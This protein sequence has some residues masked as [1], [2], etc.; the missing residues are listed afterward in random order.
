MSL[1]VKMPALLS[2]E[3]WPRKSRVSPLP[4]PMRTF[5]VQGADAGSVTVKDVP[6]LMGAL[7]MTLPVPMV[8]LGTVISATFT[9]FL[10]WLL[11]TN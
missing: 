3:F 6:G 8:E 7:A 10:D 1:K 4:K 11:I 5:R 2:Q 9:T